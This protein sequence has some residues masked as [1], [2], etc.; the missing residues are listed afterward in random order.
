MTCN[1]LDRYDEAFTFNMAG[2]ASESFAYRQTQ[3]HRVGSRER[4]ET[5]TAFL[6]QCLTVVSQ[7]QTSGESID[8]FLRVLPGDFCGSRQHRMDI[9]EHGLGENFQSRRQERR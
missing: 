2:A 3:C 8:C 5:T 7:S 4:R 9:A 6:N 1:R